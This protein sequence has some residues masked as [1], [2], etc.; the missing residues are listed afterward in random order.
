M[1]ETMA[2]LWSVEESAKLVDLTKDDDDMPEVKKELKEDA[3]GSGSGG[4]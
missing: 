4:G 2:L 1:D 3:A